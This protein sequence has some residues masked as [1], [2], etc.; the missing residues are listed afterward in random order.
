MFQ[1]ECSQKLLLVVL[2]TLYVGPVLSSRPKGVSIELASF[3]NPA[4]DFKCLDGSN[5]IPFI[6]VNDDYCDCEVRI[7][8]LCYSCIRWWFLGWFWWARNLCLSFWQVLLWESWAQVSCHSFQQGWGHSLWLL[9]WIRWVGESDL[10][11]HLWWDGK[12]C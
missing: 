7:I 11:K 12:S 1:S 3:Y 5:I 9:W 6:Q 10:Y 8:I 2:L 4:A